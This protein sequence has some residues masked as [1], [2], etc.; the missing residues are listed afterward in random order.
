MSRTAHTTVLQP[1]AN[2]FDRVFTEGG[3]RIREDEIQAVAEAEYRKGNIAGSQLVNFTYGLIKQDEEKWGKVT[4]SDYARFFATMAVA[5]DRADKVSTTGADTNNGLSADEIAS[6]N[7]ELRKVAQLAIAIAQL[8]GVSAQRGRKSKEILFTALDA[9]AKILTDAMGPEG[10][11]NFEKEL[12]KALE[13]QHPSMAFLINSIAK[14]AKN[15]QKGYVTTGEVQDAVNIHKANIA[16]RDQSD[17]GLDNEELRTMPPMY[18]AAYHV[19]R[20]IKAGIL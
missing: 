20:A 1:V 12:P 5:L 13:G 11:L 7:P 14:T 17:P 19:G 3:S 8:E 15:I 9:A 18:Q 10:R 2:L 4:K 16:R 6:L